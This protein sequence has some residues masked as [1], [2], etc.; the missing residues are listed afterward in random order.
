[1]NFVIFFFLQKK[2]F[3]K[4]DFACSTNKFGSEFLQPP[5]NTKKLF[6]F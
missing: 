2:I 4:L 1:M 6:L 3:A 5:F